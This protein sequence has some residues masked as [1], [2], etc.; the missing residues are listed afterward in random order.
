MR[1]G[2]QVFCF[3]DT[4][5]LLRHD[6]SLDIIRELLLFCLISFVAARE[7]LE[8]CE[9]SE[10]NRV[11]EYSRFEDKPVPSHFIYSRLVT[12]SDHI[13]I[14]MKIAGNQSLRGCLKDPVSALRAAP[15]L[16]PVVEHST[17]CSVFICK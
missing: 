6:L 7:I 12:V 13:V 1:S 9:E 17:L 15:L 2:T 11:R 14:I 4:F 8:D 5:A 3:F 10:G 16:L